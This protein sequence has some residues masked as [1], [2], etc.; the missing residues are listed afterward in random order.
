MLIIIICKMTHVK[1]HLISGVHEYG[2]TR[3][4]ADPTQSIIYPNPFIY[5]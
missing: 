4:S 2:S 5:G 3:E 1:V